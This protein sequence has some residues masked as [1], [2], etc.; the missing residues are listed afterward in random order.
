MIQPTGAG[1]GHLFL[2][3]PIPIVELAPRGSPHGR[4]Q[5]GQEIPPGLFFIERHFTVT[6]RLQ[7]PQVQV[8]PQSGRP[9][10]VRGHGCACVDE[11][12]HHQQGVLLNGQL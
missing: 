9:V 7:E 4:V 8:A 10:L 11:V 6:R 3:G 12:G 2:R 1:L 5:F